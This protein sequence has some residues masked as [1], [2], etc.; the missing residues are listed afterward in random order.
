MT[1]IE[2]GQ[3]LERGTLQ[4]VL[5]FRLCHAAEPA[6]PHF[7][8]WLGFLGQYRFG[9]ELLQTV[10]GNGLYAVCCGKAENVRP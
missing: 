4:G 5:L 1:G 2:V 9:D 7:A 6:Q 10:P 3:S 8:R